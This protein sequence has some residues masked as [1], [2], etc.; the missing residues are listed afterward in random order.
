MSQSVAKRPAVL[1]KTW[2][3]MIL[4]LKIGLETKSSIQSQG[5]LHVFYGGLLI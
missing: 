3:A 1:L 2:S 4:P 5:E